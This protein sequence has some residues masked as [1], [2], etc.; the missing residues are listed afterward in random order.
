MT[1]AFI[2]AVGF[3]VFSVI[4]SLACGLLSLRIISN[5]FSPESYGT[6]LVALQI[7]S[8]LPMMDGGLRTVL[9]RSLL[10]SA[11]SDQ[12]LLIEFGQKFYSWFVVIVLPI[13]LIAM[14]LYTMILQSSSSPNHSIWLLYICLAAAGTLSVFAASQA[15]L[16]LGLGSQAL[17]FLINGLASWVNLAV[18]TFSLNREFG[19]M[20][21]PLSLAAGGFTTYTL[22]IIILRNRITSF[23]LLDWKLSPHFWKTLSRFRKDAWHMFRTQL[24]I[25]LLFS[26][27]IILVGIVC[28]PTDAAIYGTLSRVFGIARN[29]L[30]SF[31]E[32]AWPIIAKADQRPRNF[33]DWL[34]Q[35]NSWFY[36]AA[37]A[38]MILLSGTFIT[39][40][41]G[42]DW[43]PSA[44]ILWLFA[45]RFLI[46][47]ASSACSYYL[48]ATGN[49][50]TLARCCEKELISSTALALLL[51]PFLGVSGIA[52]G[53]LLGTTFGTL[54]PLIAAY[55]KLRNL[56]LLTVLSAIYSRIGIA[57]AL[58]FGT[59]ATLFFLFHRHIATAISQF[60]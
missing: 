54:V 30:Q 21:F 26:V 51:Q 60:I 3:R 18:L 28:G 34:L 38:G 24:S 33:D 16:L 9:N 15:G 47:G 41:M 2:K 40:Y 31:S 1:S 35:T 57:F 13:S 42:T 58:T 43:K 12:A 14:A 53:F 10:A 39:W 19:H 48:F 20:A 27:D 7:L 46:T 17:L 11:P 5:H 45:L 59:L 29:L 37:T 32:S 44:L 50:D 4:S 55:S 36:G 52:G 22:A 56:S 8:Y 6:I 25:T 49:F 23:R